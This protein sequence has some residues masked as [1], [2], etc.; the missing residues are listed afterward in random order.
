M[1]SDTTGSGQDG[2]QGG[3]WEGD[4]EAKGMKFGVDWS[5]WEE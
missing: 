1:D 2:Q 3:D 5:D 4:I